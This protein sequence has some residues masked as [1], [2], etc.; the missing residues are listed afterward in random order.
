MRAIVLIWGTG[1]EPR[2]G[3][4]LERVLLNIVCLPL[5]GVAGIAILDN[6]ATG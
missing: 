3:T 4:V 5:K 6:L 1:E 2:G